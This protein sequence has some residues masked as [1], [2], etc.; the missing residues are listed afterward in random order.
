MTYSVAAL[1][2]GRHRSHLRRT[3]GH[4][5]CRTGPIRP[6][7]LKNKKQP[8]PAH[9]QNKQEGHTQPL[10]TQTRGCRVGGQRARPRAPPGSLRRQEETCIFL[11]IIYNNRSRLKED[12]NTSKFS[13][14]R[15]H[16]RF[17]FYPYFHKRNNVFDSFSGL[18]STLCGCFWRNISKLV[19]IWDTLWVLNGSMLQ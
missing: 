5:W 6:L 11:I 3:G 18:N 12:M 8:H 16:G 15:Q 13:S 10:P 4:S 9:P 19:H 14:S 1:G 7:R 17:G 2:T